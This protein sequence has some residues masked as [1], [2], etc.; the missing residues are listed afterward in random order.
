MNKD[1]LTGYD[2]LHWLKMLDH[3][4]LIKPIAVSEKVTGVDKPY[5]TSEEEIYYLV[6]IAYRIDSDNNF[7]GWM[8]EGL[9]KEKIQKLKEDSHL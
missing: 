6:R 5:F 4:D 9:T 7:N 1:Y 2:L 8:L 3:D